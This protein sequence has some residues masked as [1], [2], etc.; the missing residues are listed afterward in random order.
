MNT[1]WFRT[2][3]S[4]RPYRTCRNK[5]MN[6]TYVKIT[7]ELSLEMSSKVPSKLSKLSKQKGKGEVQLHGKIWEVELCHVYGATSEDLK[8]IGY[9]DKMDLPANFNRLT[10]CNLS[11]KSTCSKNAVCMAD[12]LRL[13]DA[14][15]SGTP[16]HMVVIHYKHDDTTNTK[17]VVSIVEVDLTSSH[18]EL[19]GS[20]T[21]SQLESLDKTVKLVP[22]KRKPTPQEHQDFYSI[23]DS[24]QEF[25]G[26]IHLDIKCNSSQS[27]VQCSFNRFQEFLEQHPER[28]VAQSNTNAFRGGT[29]SSLKSSRRVFKKKEHSV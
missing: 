20:L 19:F 22:Q 7:L 8:D 16:L 11:I 28:I 18:N 23:R 2:V 10:H 17:N 5:T 9:T 15:S 27:R 25:S 14:V 6:V 24:L 1:F 13:Y 21:R 4:D 12:C 29:L 26:A 3:M